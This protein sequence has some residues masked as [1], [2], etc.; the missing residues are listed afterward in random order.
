L[1]KNIVLE[2]PSITEI[3]AKFYYIESIFLL[4]QV[5]IES[6]LIYFM[7]GRVGGVWAVIVWAVR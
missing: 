6:V 7:T 5:T 4:R 1:L 3:W 2:C